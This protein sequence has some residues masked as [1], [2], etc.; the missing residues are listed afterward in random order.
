MRACHILL[1]TLT[2]LLVNPFEG[3]SATTALKTTPSAGETSDVEPIR[4]TTKRAV[5][6]H[7]TES[8]DEESVN[9]S[10]QRSIP[11]I[12]KFITGLKNW[13][14]VE[15]RLTKQLMKGE[16]NFPKMYR[17]KVVPSDLYARF[18]FG[19]LSEEEKAVNALYQMWAK[20]F[21]YWVDSNAAGKALIINPKTLI[22]GA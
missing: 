11:G 7:R 21:K 8:E 12:S 6:S 4:A 2:I 15:K 10:E 5:R 19:D 14:D 1:L 9:D 16:T 17:K 20:Y 18:K 13:A 3:A 22:Q